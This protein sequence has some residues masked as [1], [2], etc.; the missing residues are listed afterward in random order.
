MKTM[1]WAIALVI[2][3]VAGAAAQPGA[4]SGS[5][6]AAKKKIDYKLELKPSTKLKHGKVSLM[7]GTADGEPHR[8]FLENLEILSP[9]AVT[10]LAKDPSHDIQ[11]KLGKEWDKADREGSTKGKGFVTFKLRTAGDLRILISSP[12]S[13]PRPFQAVVWVGDV[14][15]AQLPAIAV[16]TSAWKPPANMPKGKGSAAPGAAPGD[17]ASSGS[18]NTGIIIAIVLVG[19]MIVVTMVVLNRRKR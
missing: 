1:T 14:A 10:V 4:G 5:G 3:A 15:K 9:I 16:K 19:L 8:L 18:G 12:D 17:P 6:S 7:A 2:A 13:E 11:V